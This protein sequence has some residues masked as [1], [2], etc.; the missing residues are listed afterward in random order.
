MLHS[1]VHC[2]YV[3]CSLPGQ[4]PVGAKSLVSRC[5]KDCR[6]RSIPITHCAFDF[7]EYFLF[8]LSSFFFFSLGPHLWHTE[9]SRLGVES[10]LQ[11]LVYTTATPDPSCG[12]D[13]HHSSRQRWI[14]NPLS[15]TRVR[16]RNF[17]VP[18]W[19]YFHSAMKGTPRTFSYPHTAP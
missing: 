4:A 15:E 8:F 18:S 14:L 16:T 11:L 7:S 6:E 17:T 9:V 3:H 12:C 10:E 5:E 1:P 2:F 19:I 13:L